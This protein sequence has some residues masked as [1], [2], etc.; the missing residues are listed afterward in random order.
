MNTT[1]SKE[2]RNSNEDEGSQANRAKKGGNT[3]MEE[4]WVESKRE[5]LSNLVHCKTMKFEYYFTK[6]FLFHRGE[7]SSSA[8]TLYKTHF[9][10]VVKSYEIM[11]SSVPNANNF[12]LDKMVYFPP[13]I[14]SSSS[15]TSKKRRL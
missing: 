5:E 14:F 8:Q 10:Q 12:V 6:L 1:T 4:S 13:N 3:F 11:N 9:Q 2:V 15:V 7:L